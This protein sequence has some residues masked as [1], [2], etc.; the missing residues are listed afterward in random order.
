RPVRGGAIQHGEGPLPGLPERRHGPS[1]RNRRRLV[2]DA[3]HHD[4]GGVRPAGAQ[5]LP[6]DEH[7]E[8]RRVRGRDGRGSGVV[9]RRT[10]PGLPLERESASEALLER[11]P[12]P[13]RPA[14]A[15]SFRAAVLLAWV[16]GGAAAASGPAVTVSEHAGRY[17]V[18]GEFTTAASRATAWAVLA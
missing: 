17:A 11:S 16:A 3:E 7:P 4:E 12:V 13:G 15:V 14:R 2:P 5:G 9:L 10:G 1:R 6:G 18:R 8:R